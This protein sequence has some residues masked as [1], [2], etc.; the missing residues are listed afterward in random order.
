VVNRGEIWCPI[1]RRLAN[2]L[3]P[4][5][6]ESCLQRILDGQAEGSADE[7]LSQR[8]FGDPWK[9]IVKAIDNF[10]SQTV[11]VREKFRVML[12]AKDVPS[13]QVSVTGL[14]WFA[15]DLAGAISF[16]S[17]MLNS[18]SCAF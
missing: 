16:K 7:N 3:L 4:V 1:C 9:K 14:L 13:C 5:V 6:E 17:F 11:R 18:S 12:E 8:R 10:A 2:V 15:L